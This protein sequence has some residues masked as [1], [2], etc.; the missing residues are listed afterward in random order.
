MIYSNRQE[1]MV[2][3]IPTINIAPAQDWVDY[4]LIDSGDGSKLER[5]GKFVFTRPEAQA[6]WSPIQTSS[7]WSKADASFQTTAEE[8]GGHWNF[9]RQIPDSWEMRYKNIS[10]KARAGASRHLGVFP[11]QAV[12]WD[13]MSELLSNAR[14]PA[15]VLNLFGYTGLASLAAAKAGAQVTHVDASKKA[16][17]WAR[18]N[19]V[20]SDLTD[21][22]IRW[23]VDD[24]L[25]FVER[26][27]RRGNLYD[28]IIMDP[29]KFGRGP[30]GEVWEFF[31]LLPQ[32]LAA[33]KGALLPKPLFFI[34]TAYAVK[35]SALTLHG[36]ISELMSDKGGSLEVGELVTAEKSGGRLIS[37]A[38]YARWSAFR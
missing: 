16:I 30:K 5:F 9:N 37:N 4:E 3:I 1:A 21:A 36:A 32:M 29:P 31:R 7:I 14:R 28:G 35:S 17:A 10:F 2:N 6:V 12:H 22:P 11:E 24:A 26:E 27:I 34:V 18:E 20:L 8:N 25:K 15:K 38:I 13:W 23:I 33:C 19:Q